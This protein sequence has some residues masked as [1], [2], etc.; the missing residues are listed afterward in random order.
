[1]HNND[2]VYLLLGHGIPNFLCFEEDGVV[3]RI[4]A[5]ALFQLCNDYTEKPMIVFLSACY[6]RTIADVFIKLGVRY[7]ITVS[8]SYV[9]DE[10]V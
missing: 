9:N 8:D 3:V 6:A 2:I 7:V 1:M 10:V 4:S 5:E